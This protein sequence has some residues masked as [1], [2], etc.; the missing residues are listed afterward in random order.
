M[1][2][3][4]QIALLPY[5]LSAETGLLASVPEELRPESWWLILPDGTPVA[6]NRGG[7][8]ILLSEIHMTRPLGRLLK[9]LHLSGLLDALDIFF[10]RQRS[11]LSPLVPKGTAPCR[12]P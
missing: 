8:V 5:T 12:F 4:E 10:A 2:R 6:G 3:R 7:G 11:K 9:A 1:D